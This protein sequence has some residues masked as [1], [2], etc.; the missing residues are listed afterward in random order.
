MHQKP[1]PGKT[2]GSGRARVLGSLGYQTE[3]SNP[4]RSKLRTCG[5]PKK[6]LLS[7]VVM[8]MLETSRLPM[9]EA[10]MPMFTTLA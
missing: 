5:G 3:F 10:S 1:D 8:K 4:A 7:G 2:G 9:R 6:P